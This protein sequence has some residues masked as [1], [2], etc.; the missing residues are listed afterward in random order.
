[1]D[2]FD[3]RRYAPATERNRVPILE[4]LKQVLPPTGIVLEVASGTGEHAVFLGPRLQPRFWQPT[5]PDPSLRASIQAWREH[6]GAEAVGSPIPLDVTDT[7]WPVETLNLTDPV[8]AIVAIN[9]IHIAPWA[10]TLGL[11]AGAAR[12]LPPQGVLYLYG[13]YKQAGRHTAPS[14]A[15]FDDQLRSQDPAWGVRN[16]DDVEAIATQH[17]LALQQVI[18]MP[19]NNLSVV[20][21]R[22]G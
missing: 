1:M 22:A 4:V 16:L 2:S 3:T 6:S 20:F 9:L 5:E 13:P 7:L 21:Q 10:A 8:T 12:L 17:H 19:A 11:M 18:S 15:Q 14:N